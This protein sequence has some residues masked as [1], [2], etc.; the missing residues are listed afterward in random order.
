MRK[1]EL[2]L[3][4]LLTWEDVISLGDPAG[5]SNTYFSKEVLKECCL[6]KEDR[7]TFEKNFKEYIYDKFHTRFPDT[8][9]P[10]EEL[11]VRMI[12]T[13]NEDGKWGIGYSIPHLISSFYDTLTESD[14]E[15]KDKTL[16]GLLLAIPDLDGMKEGAE[17]IFKQ[18]DEKYR[19]LIRN[20]NKKI[21]DCPSMLAYVEGELDDIRT[22]KRMTRW[23]LK[24]VNELVEFFAEPFPLEVLESV[25][26]DR[27]LLDMV[28]SI[29]G[30]STINKVLKGLYNIKEFSR[31][32]DEKYVIS[33]LNYIN[34]YI[35]MIDYL[36]SENFNDYL[37]E[38]RLSTSKGIIPLSSKEVIETFLQIIEPL[39]RNKETREKLGF[40]CSYQ[41]FLESKV[42]ETWRK[43]KNKKLVESIKISFDMVQSGTKVKLDRTKFVT[44]SR[45]ENGALQLK[46]DFDLLD[47]KLEYYGKK[48][49]VVE[50]VGISNFTGYFAQFYKNGCVIL[51]KLCRYVK[52]KDGSEKIV[53]SRNDAI[54]IMNYREFAKLC[55]CTKP[56][57]IE[58]KANDNPDID[59]KYHSEGW[60]AR[61]DKIIG[62]I[63]YGGLDLDFLNSLVNELAI[64]RS[65]EL[66]REATK[67]L[68][69]KKDEN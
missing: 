69:K 46:K 66:E 36:N 44:K 45:T 1:N 52:Q 65:D 64:D 53:P 22:C 68:E 14:P 29:S 23:S 60:E 3:N 28:A 16:L 32:L 11:D 27:L 61:I 31:H 56:E 30:N 35:L 4:D 50:L 6:T 57:L 37:V 2:K 43:I 55:S 63:G 58:E 10:I 49:P 12:F 18:V 39:K 25:N 9:F 13:E 34:N 54:Y 42:S 41:E 26:K 8:L 17:A 15:K 62:G 7:R 67:L 20:V 5:K 38:M 19:E 21:D 48:E 47:K 40:Y 59:R 24:N 33:C 51:D